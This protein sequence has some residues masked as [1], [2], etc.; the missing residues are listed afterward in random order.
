MLLSNMAL[1]SI[2]GILAYYQF[3]QS[4]IFI[5]YRPNQTLKIYNYFV[6]LKSDTV[7]GC[8]L[9]MISQRE[10]YSIWGGLLKAI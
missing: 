2:V 3:M 1:L 7:D 9:W 6:H 10:K 4:N 5:K 8:V